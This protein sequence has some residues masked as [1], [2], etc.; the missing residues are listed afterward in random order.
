MVAEQL[1]HIDGLDEAIAR[2][3]QE[4][5]AL[6]C[7]PQTAPQEKKPD[8]QG[9]QQQD[10]D[11]ASEQEAPPLTW[12]HAIVLLCT[13]PGVSRR[14]AKVILARIGLDMTRFPSA[15]HFARLCSEVP[16]QS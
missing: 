5:A 13:I 3:G 10:T 11:A 12:A 15:G 9:V 8:A 1:R 2:V 6:M 14:A 16:R 4:I 7:S